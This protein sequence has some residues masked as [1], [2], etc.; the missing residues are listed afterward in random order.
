MPRLKSLYQIAQKDWYL[1]SSSG[2]PDE[3]EQI[4]QWMLRELLVSY[5]FP[6]KWLGE[7]IVLRSHPAFFGIALLTR[8]D[9]PFLLVSISE[10][11]APT[12]AQQNLR[13]QLLE[14]YTAGSGIATDGSQEGTHFL[15]RRFDSDRCEF[16]NDIEPYSTPRSGLASQ[17]YLFN[18][19]STSSHK[20]RELTPLTT[21][22]ENIFFEKVIEG[23]WLSVNGK[24]T[25][26]GAQIR[27]F[28]VCGKTGST[29]VISS[30]KAN[31]L[32][33]QKIEVKTHSW[34]TGFA[35]RDDPKIVVTVIV[36]YGGGGG[37]T[38][39]PLARNIF[40]SFREGYDR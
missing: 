29:Q 3:R 20:S 13:S 9:N 22:I 14:S 38:A 15:R 33:Q 23:M 36:E 10:P 31:K 11:G 6:E 37:E 21:N 28:D 30:E 18:A 16:I 17:P 12:V 40:D 1:E 4:R 35:P 27:G 25:G 32:A 8:E 19:N 5:R 7:R 34:F 39:A 2:K 26:R 24:G